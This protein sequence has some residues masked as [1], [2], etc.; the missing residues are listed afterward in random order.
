[1]KFGTKP[2][3]VLGHRLPEPRL[4]WGAKLAG[5]ALAL[6]AASVLGGLADLAA[7]TFFGVCTGLW[8]AR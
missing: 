4:T 7:Q 8:C 2:A 5:L 1:M 6:V 3:K